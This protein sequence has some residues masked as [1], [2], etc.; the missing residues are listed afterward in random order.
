MKCSLNPNKIG[1][2]SN[3]LKNNVNNRGN[4]Q[5][6][7]TMNTNGVRLNSDMTN[8]TDDAFENSEDN[9]DIQTV[10]VSI[11]NKILRF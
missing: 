4:I 11:F 7:G 3:G 8:K 2:N 6:Y 10:V 1:M 5:I 9:E